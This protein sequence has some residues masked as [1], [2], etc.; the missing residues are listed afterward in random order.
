MPPPSV[1]RTFYAAC[2]ALSLA[3]GALGL[4]LPVLPTTPFVLLAA[5]FFSKGS[6]RLHAALLADPLFGPIV[7]D[8][9]ERGAVRPGAKVTATV[10]M[11]A[12][13][14]VMLSTGAAAP[15]LK[16]GALAVQAAVLVFLWTR[17]SR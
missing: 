13:A 14:A 9:E 7:R 11:A 3:L 16:G 15:W 6:P 17:P 2:G 12:L 1:P 8:W 4:F 10:L 5:F